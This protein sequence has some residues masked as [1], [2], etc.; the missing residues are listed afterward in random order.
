L[1]LTDSDPADPEES[2][3]VAVIFSAG[4]RLSK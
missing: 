4:Y 2:P 3:K 1:S